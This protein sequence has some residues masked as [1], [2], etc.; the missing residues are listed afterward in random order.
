MDHP[1]LTNTVFGE[2]LAELLETRGLEATPFKVGK[3]AEDAGLDGWKVL[4]R[5]AD[6]SANYGG[7]LDG[8]VTALALS[9]WEMRELAHAFA[10]EQRREA[11]PY[12]EILGTV[13]GQLG[14]A[15]ELLDDVPPEAF[16]SEDDYFRA[17]A[18]IA[19]AGGLVVRAQAR[20]VEEA[21]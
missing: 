15:I 12:A 5:M 13:N 6:A 3:L 11:T 4:D 19:E 14:G 20:Q 1:E 2:V 16:G 7:S 18:A 10:F 21:S 9:R 17:K 8:L